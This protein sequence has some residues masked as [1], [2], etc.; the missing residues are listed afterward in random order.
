MNPAEEEKNHPYRSR[1]KEERVDRVGS[2]PGPWMLEGG[3]IAA[4]LMRERVRRL[5][6]SWSTS[7]GGGTSRGREGK[8]SGSRIKKRKKEC[9]M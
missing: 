3:C 8:M 4:Y 7:Q 9:V 6:V 1:E 5:V 2:T